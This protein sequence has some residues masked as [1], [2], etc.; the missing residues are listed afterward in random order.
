LASAL[1]D[2]TTGAVVKTLIRILLFGA[3]LSLTGC[4]REPRT[5]RD[6]LQTS[7][8]SRTPG[9][10]DHTPRVSATAAAPA[11]GQTLPDGGAPL[12]PGPLPGSGKPR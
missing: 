1:L 6:P 12:P 10:V 8:L 2:M 5:S 3:V 7:Q 11:P 4:D 9:N